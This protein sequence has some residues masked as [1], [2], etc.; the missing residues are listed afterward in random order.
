MTKFI[1]PAVL[2]AALAFLPAHAQAGGISV[3][4]GSGGYYPRPSIPATGWATTATRPTT[5]TRRPFTTT[6]CPATGP[7][8][9]LTTTRR[10]ATSGAVGTGTATSGEST[11]NTNTTNITTIEKRCGEEGRSNPAFSVFQV[12]PR[13]RRDRPLL[14][15]RR[16]R[17]LLAQLPHF[18]AHLLLLRRIRRVLQHVADPRRD[19]PHLRLAHAARRQGRR[20]DAHARRVQRRTR[21][22]RECRCG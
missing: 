3:T 6:T 5:A 7:T 20:A 11:R 13:C 16:R 14:P 21:V 8:S 17:E 19:L 1:L 22:E 9:G 10:T 4:I 15:V 2:A 12:T 18:P